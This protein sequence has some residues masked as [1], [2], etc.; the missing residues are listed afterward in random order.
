MAPL[1]RWPLLVALLAFGCD[2]QVV[3]AVR[4]PPPVEKPPDPPKPPEPPSPL[5]TSLIHRY[6]FDGTGTQALD[7]KGA[8]HGQLVGAQLDGSGSLLLSGER[9]GQYVNL[10][11]GLVSGLDNATF[12]AWLT[13]QGGGNWQRIFDFGSSTAGEDM[14]GGGVRYLFLTTACAPDTVR[15]LPSALRLAYSQNGV[16]N[17]DIC[18]SNEAFPIGVPTH[19]AVVIDHDQRLMTLYQAGELVAQCTLTRRLSGID[20]VND[21]LGHSNFSADDDL[22]G[23]YDEFRVYSAALSAEQ[24]ADSF[25]AGPDAEP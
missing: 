23:S 4:E 16:G 1:P 12:E 24:I 22:S 3:D 14:A 9:S 11:N 10:P 5:E 18:Q 21:W 17:E 19:V 2:A 20:D 15:G 6:S 7:S 25:A 8:A 13:W